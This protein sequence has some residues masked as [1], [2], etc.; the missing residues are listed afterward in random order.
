M[1]RVDCKNCDEEISSRAKF[2]PHCGTKQKKK[3]GGQ[4]SID[5]RDKKTEKLQGYI[6]TLQGELEDAGIS[7]DPFEDEDDD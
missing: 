1:A 7:Y 3:K 6:E 4:R 5:N 2:C